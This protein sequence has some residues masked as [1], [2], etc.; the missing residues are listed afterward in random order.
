MK[1]E[2]KP[3]ELTAA[4]LTGALGIAAVYGAG[5]LGA[6]WTSSGPEPGYFPFYV[7]LILIAASIGNAVMALRARWQDEDPWL[8][9]DQSLR[10]AGFLLPL[11]LYVTASVWLGLYVASAAYVAYNARFRGGYRSAVALAIGIGF[12]VLLYVVFEIAF[13]VPLL[14]GPLEPMLGIN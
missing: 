3:A 2:R 5:E 4:A 1:I 12:S 6:S 11:V 14:K 10:L 7:G 13:K 9:R 8:T